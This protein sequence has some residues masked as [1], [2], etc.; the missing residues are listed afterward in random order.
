MAIRIFQSNME[1]NEG[2]PFELVKAKR[3]PVTVSTTRKKPTGHVAFARRRGGKVQQVGAKGFSGRKPEYVQPP[4]DRYGRLL[5]PG[6]EVILE[7]GN[8]FY[9][10]L[11]EMALPNN[12]VKLLQGPVVPSR[13]VYLK[14]PWVTGYAR[15]T[16]Q[17]VYR[18]Q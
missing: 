8:K 10:Y 9:R 1:I 16:G 12:S 3:E 15:Q 7:E 5:K 6:N 17:M 13:R 14:E 11:V 4:K 2:K 18:D